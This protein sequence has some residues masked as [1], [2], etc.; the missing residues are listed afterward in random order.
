MSDRDFVF[1]ELAYLRDPF[2]GVAYSIAPVLGAGRRVFKTPKQTLSLDG[3]AGALFGD[4]SDIGRTTG[5][6]VKA[7][8]NYEWAISTS[9]RLTQKATAIW[10]VSDLSDSLYHFDSALTTAI[11]SRAELKIA[12]NYDFKNRQAS[13][14][15]KKADS[16][17]VTALVFKF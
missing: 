4:E 9:S 16:T 3:A 12:Y 1:A 15:V 7:G 2:K 6:S 13:P 10:K 11:A 17:L 8:E 14:T 5:A